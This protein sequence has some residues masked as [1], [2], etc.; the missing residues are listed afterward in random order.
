MLPPTAAPVAAGGLN[1]VLRDA[2]IAVAPRTR[3]IV[4]RLAPEGLAG[5]AEVRLFDGTDRLAWL[6][7][8][9]LSPIRP[10]ASA[11]APATQRSTATSASIARYGRSS[12]P[13]PRRRRPDFRQVDAAIASMLR[14]AL[15]DAWTTPRAMS[16]PGM[17]VFHAPI[18]PVGQIMAVP[19]MPVF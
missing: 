16:T 8:D 4:L 15:A 6:A 2:M 9:D 14:A 3:A 7:A 5:V 10:P 17:P 11:A 1:W 13:R 12:G 18:A 19:G